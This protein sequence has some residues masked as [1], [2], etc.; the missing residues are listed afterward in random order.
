MKQ[1]L[2]TPPASRRAA[3]DALM[4]LLGAAHHIEAQLES[5]LAVHGLSMA[6][7]GVLEA[8]AHANAP[9][10]LTE[11]AGKLSCVR[12]NVTQLIDRLEADGLVRRVAD[13]ADR[14][15]IR[16]V[17]TPEGAARAH[18]GALAFAQARR[19]IEAHLSEAEHG[20]LLEALARLV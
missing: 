2:P 1:T 16:A 11:L 15:S 12:S 6:K 4:A 8:L 13:E 18:A 17:L 9:L 7:F 5:A 14:R 3:D 19:G 10:T 20:A